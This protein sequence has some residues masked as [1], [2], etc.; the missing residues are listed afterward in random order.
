MSDLGARQDRAG[1]RGLLATLPVLGQLETIGHLVDVHVH[2][3]PASDRIR[4]LM[5]VVDFE[6]LEKHRYAMLIA[7]FENL[8]R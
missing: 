8:I 7:R 1:R 3:V 6:R 5:C 2:R 4:H